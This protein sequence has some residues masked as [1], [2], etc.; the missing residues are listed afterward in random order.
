[1]GDFLQQ[2][3]ASSRERAAAA[4]RQYSDD[5]LD[6]PVA[7]L[8]HDRFDVIA[9]IKAQSPSEGA[10]AKAGHD[11]LQQARHYADGGA[12]AVSVLTEPS[13]FGGEL[14]H[15]REVAALLAGVG[16]PAMRKDFLVERAQLLEARAY[17]AS[18]ALLITAMLDDRTLTGMLDCA[19]ELSM[20]VLLEAFDEAD[21]ERTRA[22]LENARY[23]DTARDGMLLVGV[24]TRNLRTLDVDGDRLRLLSTLLPASAIAVA[25]SGLRT[26][27]DAAQAAALGYRMALVGSAL[28]Q[29]DEPT[30]LL[31]AMREAGRAQVA[32]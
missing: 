5:E 29:S 2:M 31:S 25:E 21:L 20:F 12:A 24:N 6:L 7:R 10:L 32:V 19:R 14:G 23:A 30:V 8:R 28:M 1:M 4:R 16:I 3:A 13:R 26:A 17:G 15:L 9:E 18:G 22:L 11:R 27:D